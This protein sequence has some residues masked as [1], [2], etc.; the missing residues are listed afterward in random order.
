L[1]GNRNQM[2]GCERSAAQIAVHCKKSKR[3]FD[4]AALA[5]LSDL[6]GRL[7]AS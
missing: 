4:E 6:R 2:F 5:E 1:S 7:A 3:R